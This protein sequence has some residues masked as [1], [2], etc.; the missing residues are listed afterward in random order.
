MPFQFDDLDTLTRLLEAHRGEVAAV[1]LG[2]PH[3]SE[4][5]AEHLATIREPAH[6]HGALLVWDEVVTGFRLALGGAHE[7]LGVIPDLAVFAKAMANGFPVAA[8]V[9]RSE[10][11]Q[12]TERLMITETYGG[13]ALSLAACVATVHEYRERD[14]ISCFWRLG[15][16][17]ID[18]L[19][20]AAEE[21]C[22]SGEATAPTD[23][24]N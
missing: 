16:R 1:V 10:V 20:A 19:N 15:Q 9:G 21:V 14:V 23:G 2:A 22:V 8:V 12:V 6:D 13:E 17:L 3:D 24:R 18:G 5:S 7:H 11:M 4:T